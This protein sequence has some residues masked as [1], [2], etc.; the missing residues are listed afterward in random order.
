MKPITAPIAAEVRQDQESEA[1]I[2]RAAKEA[3]STCNWKL[4]EC[5]SKWNLN[6][7]RGRGDGD[8]GMAVGMSGD[9]IYQRRRVWERWGGKAVPAL[10]WS[11]F[12]AAL[13]WDDADDYLEWSYANSATVAEMRAYRTAKTAQEFLP[14]AGER[15]GDPFES[16]DPFGEGEEGAGTDSGGTEA[17]GEE[18]GTEPEGTDSEEE[19]PPRRRRSGRE[20]PEGEPDPKEAFH[21]H[22]ART[23]KTIEALMRAID[24]FK[25]MA[26]LPKHDAMIKALQKMLA[27]IKQV[28]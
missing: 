4:G 15:G 25:N 17:E 27:E 18:G 11:H 12:Y 7:A 24:D 21:N 20:E 5:A 28:Q 2:I 6:W 14:P 19:Q 23:V 3:I 1:A 9:Q 10:S 22:K 16:E 26:S 8:F 13:N